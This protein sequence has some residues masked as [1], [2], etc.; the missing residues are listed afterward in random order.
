MHNLISFDKV[1]YWSMRASMRNQLV[2]SN[3]YD[4]QTQAE[5]IVHKVATIPSYGAQ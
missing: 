1:V 2:P 5:N 4:G 3:Y